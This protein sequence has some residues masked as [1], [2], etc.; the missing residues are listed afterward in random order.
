MV[1]IQ[2]MQYILT[3]AEE[4]QFLRASSRCFVTQPTLSMQIKK[5]EDELGHTVFDRSS[6]PLELTEFGKELLPIIR[7]VLNEYAR[8][9]TMMHV[10]AGTFKEKLRIAVIPTIAGY[11]L[12]DMFDNWLT[13]L[14][15]VELVIEELK[16]EEIL[17]ALEEKRID[18]GILAGPVHNPKWRTSVLFHEEIRVYGPSIEKKL[19]TPEELEVYNPWLLSKGNCLRTQMIHFCQLNEP[20]RKKWN[21]EGGNIELLLKMVDL[22]GGYTLVPSNYIGLLDLKD[23]IRVVS[24]DQYPAREVI[25]VSLNRSP[26]WKHI[27]KIIRSIQLKYSNDQSNLQL[28]DWN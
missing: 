17:V 19:L 15:D 12:P 23:T 8:I 18:V 25:A 7:D 9:E 14:D 21:Y 24:N 22:N 11:L 16:S 20:D 27:E 26:K 4:R 13:E 3:L 1:T 2:Q 6:S 28:L 5:A 10:Q